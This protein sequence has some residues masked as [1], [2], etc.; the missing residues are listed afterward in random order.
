[1][2]SAVLSVAI[3][4]CFIMLRTNK[5]VIQYFG[6]DDSLPKHS[7][8]SLNLKFVW[9]GQCSIIGCNFIM[10]HTNKVVIQ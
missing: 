7:T 3:V 1:M 4:L 10:F 6:F 9:N 5:V 2:A 8:V